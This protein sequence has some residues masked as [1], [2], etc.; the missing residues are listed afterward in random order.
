MTYHA[1]SITYIG[2][3]KDVV[4]VIEKGGFRADQKNVLVEI[5]GALERLIKRVSCVDKMM[6]MMM[7]TMTMMMTIVPVKMNRRLRYLDTRN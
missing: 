7:T 2:V 6:M 4:L 5:N 3:H 1:K